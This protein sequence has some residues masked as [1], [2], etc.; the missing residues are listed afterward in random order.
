MW[1]Q[2]ISICADPLNKE[3]NNSSKC[4]IDYKTLQ[5]FAL[6]STSVEDNPSP[7]MD[8]LL[9]RSSSYL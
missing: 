6:Q 9:L 3:E 4:S 1:L 2:R 5:I 8:Q 7:Q